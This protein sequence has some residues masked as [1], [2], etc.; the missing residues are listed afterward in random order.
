MQHID[1]NEHFLH[2]KY[3]IDNIICE[4]QNKEGYLSIEQKHLNIYCFPIIIED[5]ENELSSFSKEIEY[6]KSK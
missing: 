1:L 2:P 3:H 6:L 4:K 5:F